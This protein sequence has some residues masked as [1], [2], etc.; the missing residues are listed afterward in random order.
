MVEGQALGNDLFG[1]FRAVLERVARHT[2]LPAPHF[3]RGL[4]PSVSRF[5]HPAQRRPAHMVAREAIDSLRN[6]T[7]ITGVEVE[8]DLLG[9]AIG[10]LEAGG[11]QG[12]G[13]HTEAFR[14][15]QVV[16]RARCIVRLRPAGRA[17]HQVEH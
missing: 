12:V 9:N 11:R 14:H 17:C 5:A 13:G 8:P 4:L 7:R 1:V 3:L 15:V 10:Q 16:D 6:P 2:E